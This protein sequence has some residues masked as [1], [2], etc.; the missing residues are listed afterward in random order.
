MAGS[1]LKSQAMSDL[2]SGLIN[3]KRADD[4]RVLNDDPTALAVDHIDPLRIDGSKMDCCS[5]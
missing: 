3:H 4:S 2:E 5:G 1:Q